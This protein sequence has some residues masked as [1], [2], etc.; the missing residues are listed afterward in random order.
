MYYAGKAKGMSAE[1]LLRQIPDTDIALAAAI[2][3][4]AGVLGLNQY[5]GLRLG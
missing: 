1:P 3:L 2:E 5:S 4:A